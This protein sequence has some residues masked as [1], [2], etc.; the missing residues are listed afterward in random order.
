MAGRRKIS[1]SRLLVAGATALAAGVLV[2][3]PGGAPVQAAS[4][5]VTSTANSGAGTLRDAMQQANANPGEDTITF[6][7]PNPSTIAL[8]NNITITDDVRIEGPGQTALTVTNPTSRVFDVNAG[9][10]YIDSM[11]IDGAGSNAI[12]FTSPSGDVELD[13]MT[14]SDSANHALNVESAASV[15]VTNSALTNAQAAGFKGDGVHAE[16][17]SGDVLIED[18]VA[19]GNE[20]N[21]EFGTPAA[22]SIGGTVTLRRVTATSAIDEAADFQNVGGVV[23]ESSRF[24]ANNDQIDINFVPGSVSITDTTVSGTEIDDGLEIS[25]VAG[26]AVV[27]RTTLSGSGMAGLDV[28]GTLT[29]TTLTVVNSTISGNDTSG[30]IVASRQHGERPALDDHGERQPW[31]QRCGR[32]REA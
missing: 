2:M 32:R 4:Y 6:N 31:R 21:F 24:D 14:I 15:T 7:L 23:I 16:L 8:T 13:D 5:V 28:A 19:S 11:T 18:V 12:I 1:H 29:A 17:V 3:L 20:D 27:A 9:S 25:D 22:G 30:I 26:S 10:V